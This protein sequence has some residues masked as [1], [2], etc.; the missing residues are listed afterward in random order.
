M[1]RQTPPRISSRQHPWTR[2]RTR[3]RTFKPSSL[4]SSSWDKRERNG[5][6]ACSSNESSTRSTSDSSIFR[7]AEIL[8]AELQ[9]QQQR[10][11]EDIDRGAAAV[12]A[13]LFALEKRSRIVSPDLIRTEDDWSDPWERRSTANSVT[14]GASPQSGSGSSDFSGGFTPEKK[15]R[16][17]PDH[18]FESFND[19]SKSLDLSGV[20]DSPPLVRNSVDPIK[21]ERKKDNRT[22]RCGAAERKRIMSQEEIEPHFHSKEALIVSDEEEEDW[23]ENKK[24]DE[25]F[26]VMQQEVPEWTDS[27]ATTGST[28][29]PPPPPSRDPLASAL[30]KQVDEQRI[31]TGVRDLGS[32][33]VMVP[34]EHPY[35]SLRKE[36]AAKPHPRSF[37]TSDSETSPTDSGS[38]QLA[39]STDTFSVGTFSNESPYSMS[40]ASR[41]NLRKQLAAKSYPR[42]FRTSD[43]ETSPS[44]SGSEQLAYSTDTFSVGTFSNESP[45]SMSLASQRNETLQYSA[46]LASSASRDASGEVLRNE[47]RLVERTTRRLSYGSESSE[48]NTVSQNEANLSRASSYLPGKY[49][50]LSPISIRNDDNDD[51][52]SYIS[53]RVQSKDVSSTLAPRGV[54]PMS[55]IYSKLVRD[56]AYRHALSAGTL[57]QTLVSQHVRFPG[58]WW[59]GDRSPQ[60]GMLEDSY[61]NGKSFCSWQYVSRNRVYS[62]PLLKKRVRN[63]ASPGRILLHVIVRDLMT[64]LPVQDIVIGCFHPNARGIRRKEQPDPRDEDCRE[65]WMAVR[66]H[67]EDGSVSVVDRLLTEGRSIEDVAQNSP[68]GGL[69]RISNQNMR[70]VRK[71]VD[72]IRCYL[73]Y[74]TLISCLLH[75]L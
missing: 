50:G 34:G 28:E 30:H 43:S 58:H 61:G 63:R 9:K 17:Y 6:D 13:Q 4:A 16:L 39:Y 24:E 33:P 66:K 64:L 3:D 44:D 41:R 48:Y 18:T 27:S 20:A 75:I 42:S 54:S 11:E 46:S 73:Y 2:N 35:T 38:E 32:F 19:I 57:W 52:S 70:A 74:D 36:L 59:D 21:D 14:S 15:S 40:V 55:M 10:S 60:M 37:R 7:G 47:G 29:E 23:A 65:V 56:P 51:V 67:S 71:F 72:I 8:R 26:S 45:Y 49:S 1:S 12:K 53:D 5:W 31:K 22:L 62:N 68:L 69:P 25:L